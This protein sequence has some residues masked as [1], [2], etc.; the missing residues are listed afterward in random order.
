M[1]QPERTKYTNQNRR[2]RTRSKNNS[3]SK[4]EFLSARKSAIPLPEQVNDDIRH[5]V[6]WGEK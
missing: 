6:R 4:I 1:N 2:N 3:Y 5:I